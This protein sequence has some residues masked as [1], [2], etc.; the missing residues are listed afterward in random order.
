MASLLSATELPDAQY[1][2]SRA[3]RKGTVL[4]LPVDLIPGED[5]RGAV[6]RAAHLNAQ[7]NTAYIVELAR[8]RSFRSLTSVHESAAFQDLEQLV[9][10]LGIRKDAQCVQRLLSTERA[11]SRDWTRF[12]GIRVRRGQLVSER[13]VAP[14]SLRVHPYQRAVWALRPFDFDLRSRERL[15][16]SCPECKRKLGW[17]QSFGVCYCDKCPAPGSSYKGA[18]DLRDFPQ[19]VV[20]VVDE[21]ALDF[22]RSLVDTGAEELSCR[23]HPDL[24]TLSRGEL[25]QL[26]VRVARALEPRNR[27]RGLKVESI[28]CA[29]RAVLSWPQAFEELSDRPELSGLLSRSGKHSFDALQNDP[30]LSIGAR[31]LLKQQSS[32][33]LRRASARHCHATVDHLSGH[34]H[35]AYVTG[36]RTDLQR[37][38]S[39][40]GATA[41]EVAVALLRNSAEQR[42]IAATLGLPTPWLLDL[43]LAGISTGSTEFLNGV[44]PVSN[45]PSTL[46]L[47]SVIADFASLASPPGAVTLYRTVVALTHLNGA[48]CAEMLRAIFDG[49]QMVYI[50]SRSV[51]SVLHRLRC[52]RIDAR[53][54]V[55]RLPDEASATDT[56]SLTQSDVALALGKP[57]TVIWE[58]VRNG[59]LATNSTF[60]DLAQFRKNWMFLSEVLELARLEAPEDGGDIR[61]S[62][63]SSRICRDRAGE[64]T[65]W[66][67]AGVM[68]HL[69]AS[70][71]YTPCGPELITALRR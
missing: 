2:I 13:R 11:T 64:V 46:L 22:V 3:K 32:A 43:Y 34:N 40:T 57:R 23:L 52:T 38:A 10:V 30:T 25:F 29:A 67:R 9:E 50:D 63:R 21:E 5:I 8:T 68:E 58:L 53:S 39:S 1:F 7:P 17:K 56:V 27:L 69:R 70:L 60:R 36:R 18:V 55:A 49:T 6:L 51:G 42:R 61:Q 47:P 65:I 54:L 62:L 12:A 35:S 14:L 45:R 37:T 71:D 33:R 31:R 16:D 28:E 24:S 59:F 66:S 15:L 4:P 44:W 48:K 19:S 26:T 20:D 41:A